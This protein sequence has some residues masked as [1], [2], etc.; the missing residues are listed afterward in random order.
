MI[1]DGNILYQSCR[2]LK[3]KADDSDLMLTGAYKGDWM[4]KYVNKEVMITGVTSRSFTIH[5]TL[6]VT[7][8]NF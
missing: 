6:F 5:F 1:F 8:T 2:W 4:A 3:N 7:I